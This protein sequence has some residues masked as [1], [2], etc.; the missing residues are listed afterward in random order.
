M[1]RCGEVILYTSYSPNDEK[2]KSVVGIFI[3]LQLRG[4]VSGEGNCKLRFKSV[5]PIGSSVPKIADDD[6]QRHESGAGETF[7]LGCEGQS[8]PPPDFR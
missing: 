6:I 4:G 8:H 5:E 7:S 3:L 2:S 1:R